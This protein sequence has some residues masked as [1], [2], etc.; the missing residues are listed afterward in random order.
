MESRTFEQAEKFYKEN[1]AALLKI[2]MD[3]FKGEIEYQEGFDQVSVW[4][5]N[6][7]LCYQNS[8]MNGDGRGKAHWDNDGAN[9]G[10]DELKEILKKDNRFNSLIAKDEYWDE[11]YL[12]EIVDDFCA[13]YS[14]KHNIED[15]FECNK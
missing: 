14:K 3:E 11:E 13:E 8:D 12:K 5:D 9:C 7:S 4:F 1:K 6:F 15:M 10:I 2:M